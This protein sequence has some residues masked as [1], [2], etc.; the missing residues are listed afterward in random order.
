MRVHRV[1]LPDL[2]AGETAVTGS[3]ALHLQ[4]VLRVRPGQPVRAFDGQGMEADGQV[5][6][7]EEARVL[8]QLEAPRPARVEAQ[9]AVTVAV[10]L[11]KG[12]KLASVVRQ[13]TELGAARFLP[14]TSRHADVR[15]LKGNKLERLRRVSSEAA[16]QSGRAVIPD[17]DEAMPLRRLVDQL[18]GQSVIYADP[19]AQL[20][21]NEAVDR[22]S[23]AITV[24]SGP[25]GGFSAE[26]RES[27]GQAGF[28]G[29]R[30]GARILRAETAPVALVSALLLPEGL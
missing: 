5:V 19:R 23:A 28:R 12:D 8:L 3:G 10:A 1:H 6:Q 26:E 29:V 7:V 20:T 15:E 22:D 11:L 27:F 24:M 9:L 4:R 30:L 21:I 25:E 18:A 13:C 14:F 16:K 17:V 2:S